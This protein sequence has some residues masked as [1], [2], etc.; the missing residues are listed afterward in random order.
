MTAR[1]TLKEP[2]I[3]IADVKVPE[4]GESI[5]EGVLVAWSVQE[6]D[7]VLAGDALFELETD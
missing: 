2:Q 4:V 7:A 5:T 6:G 1:L 3:M